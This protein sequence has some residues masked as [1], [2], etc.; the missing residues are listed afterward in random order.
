MPEPHSENNR[1][2][3]FE[4]YRHNILRS[5]LET[6]GALD[7][8]LRHAIFVRAS[9]PAN[10]TSGS[11]S[12][13]DCPEGLP[14]LLCAFVDKVLQHAYKVT[15]GDIERL[16]DAGYSEDAIFETIV[17]AAAGAGLFRLDRGLNVM[18]PPTSP[19]VDA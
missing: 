14:T 8:S 15:D 17:A 18:N 9:A 12:D 4:S 19:K 5:V 11:E 2:D 13:P 3:R 6:P 7:P 1:T 10:S 16:R